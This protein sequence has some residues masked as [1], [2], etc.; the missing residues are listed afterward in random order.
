[1]L[2]VNLPGIDGIEFARRARAANF[3]GRILISSGRLT[4]AQLQAIGQLHVNRI[5]PKPFNLQ[6]FQTAVREC[7]A[8]REAPAHPPH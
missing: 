4:A 3:P 1:M 8:P 2:D 5:L 6:E 7:L